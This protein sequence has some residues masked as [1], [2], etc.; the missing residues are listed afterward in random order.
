MSGRILV[1][2]D[3]ATN[4]MIL[5]AKLAASYFD[6]IQAENG[7]EAIAKTHEQQPDII[8]LDIMMPGMNGFETCRRLKDDP[9]TAHIPVI[10][11]TSLYESDD[12][13]RGLECGADD[14][15]SKPINDLAL[16]SRVRNLLRSKFM[17]DELRLRHRTTKDLG[18]GD[19]ALGGP[20]FLPEPGQVVLM[21]TDAEMGEKWLAA[22][23]GQPD[24]SCRICDSEA[25]ASTLD[26]A[27]LPDVFVIH[28]RLGE[29]SDGLRLVSYLR[30]RPNTRN[31]SVILVVPEGDQIKA[32]KGLD[33]GASDYIFD[34]FDPSELIVRLKSQIR[35]KQIS[36]R[37]RDNVTDTLRLAVLDPL[38]GLYNRRYAKQHLSKITERARQ[39]GKGFALM[40]LDIDKFK[41][42]NDTHGH[43]MGDEVLKEFSRRI[44]ENLRG[45]DL[46]S[47]LGGEE[48][49]VAMPDTTENQA[50]LASERLRQ[51]IEK[52]EFSCGKGIKNLH[53]TVSIGVTLGDPSAQDVDELISQA[54]RALY[55]SKSEGRN[56]VTLYNS[57]A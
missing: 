20:D 34:D 35:R 41:L 15:I 7:L 13:L 14:F 46:V 32:A 42:V 38:T 52:A 23:A 27:S 17:L 1:V 37:L 12:R 18:L 51:V 39:T 21:P 9:T 6:V 10:M 56:M 53:V 22:L 55:A 57:A 45:V 24:F 5:R 36:D 2:D 49:L 29:F 33:L 16:F 19:N 47:R 44:Q 11:V 8:L 50:R 25:Q 48:F 26:G 43:S 3:I 40:L 4:R 54:D 28:A 31:A 30:S